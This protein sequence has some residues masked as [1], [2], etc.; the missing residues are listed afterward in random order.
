MRH[1]LTKR[2][3]L[4]GRM[5]IGTF[6]KMRVLNNRHLWQIS[7][8]QETSC[9]K[10]LLEGRCL[11]KRCDLAIFTN[12][13]TFNGLPI[14]YITQEANRVTFIDNANNRLLNSR[15]LCPANYIA[16]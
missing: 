12:N 5:L 16:G 14:D 6:V 8:S 7:L 1:N 11:I 15:G 10:T 3:F 9:L 2:T 13:V 4:T